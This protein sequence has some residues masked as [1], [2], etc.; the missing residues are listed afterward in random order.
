MKLEAP[1][2]AVEFA[3]CSCCSALLEAEAQS[4]STS[5]AKAVSGRPS[6]FHLPQEFPVPL[7]S[8][9]YGHHTIYCLELQAMGHVWG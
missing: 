3:T 1:I 6:L 4:V 9:Y 7:T 5:W 8:P 2:A